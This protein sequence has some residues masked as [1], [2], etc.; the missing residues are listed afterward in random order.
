MKKTQKIFALL[1]AV[2]MIFSCFSMVVMAEEEKQN[3]TIVGAT[4]INE[5]EYV[6]EFSAPVRFNYLW[7]TFRR[8][9]GYG[10]GTNQNPSAPSASYL[11][12]ITTVDGKEY[13][14]TVKLTFKN[15]DVN[16]ENAFDPDT[17]HW[18]KFGISIAEYGMNT[19]EKGDA[20]GIISPAVISG[21][22]GEYVASN[23]VGAN[24]FLWIPTGAADPNGTYSVHLRNEDDIKIIGAEVSADKTT[25][26]LRFSDPVNV[27]AR[28]SVWFRANSPETGTGQVFPDSV[29]YL[30]KTYTYGGRVYSDTVKLVI[31]PDGGKDEA[32]GNKTFR[33]ATNDLTSYGI[34]FTEYTNN[35]ATHAG[36]VL[37]SVVT[38]AY[39]K[40]VKGNYTSGGRDFLWVPTYAVDTD[41]AY[42]VHLN[43]DGLPYVVSA[44]RLAGTST[45]RVEFSEPVAYTGG[46]WDIIMRDSP[47]SG[48][49]QAK[50]ASA[51]PAVSGTT[52]TVD[53]VTY[54]TI[55][56]FKSNDISAISADGA[57]GMAICEYNDTDHKYDGVVTA[58]HI[59][60]VDG[61]GLMPTYTGKPVPERNDPGMDLCWI[62]TDAADTANV[63]PIHLEEEKL[64]EKIEVATYEALVEAVAKYSKQTIY[65]TEDLV[66][67][68]GITYEYDEETGKVLILDTEGSVVAAY[69]TGNKGTVGGE[70]IEGSIEDLA[71]WTPFNVKNNVIDFQDHKVSGWVLGASGNRYGIF[72]AIDATGTVKNLNIENVFTCVNGV[73]SARIGA[74]AAQNW[75]TVE[76]VHIKDAVIIAANSKNNYVG[77]AVGYMSSSKAAQNETF[78]STLYNVTTDGYLFVYSNEDSTSPCIGGILGKTNGGKI[79]NC[80]NYADIYQNSIKSYGTGGIVGL[81]ETAAG[82]PFS[83]TTDFTTK[84]LE[85]M[86]VVNNANYGKIE[87]SAGLYAGGL[88]GYADAI[89]SAGSS[90][91]I[92]NNF[93]GAKVIGGKSGIVARSQ[94]VSSLGSITAVYE[95][96]FDDI[97]NGNP[98]AKLGATFAAN[99]VRLTTQ[100]DALENL[101]RN[102]GKYQAVNGEE[103]AKAWAWEK[104]GEI[105]LPVAT[106]EVG[107]V[108][109]ATPVTIP[110]YTF[111]PETEIGILSVKLAKPGWLEVTFSEPVKASGCYA[112]I[113]YV[114][115][116]YGIP[117]LIYADLAGDGSANDPVQFDRG[118]TI[119]TDY[120]KVYFAI[121]D[122]TNAVSNDILDKLSGAAFGDKVSGH[123]VAFCIEG[124]PV[125][126]GEALVEGMNEVGYIDTIT[127]LDGTKKL[128][129]SVGKSNAS[130]TYDGVY[131]AIENPYE[132]GDFV[133]PEASDDYVVLESAELAGPH[134]LK[135][136][137]SE[138]VKLLEGT[139]AWLSIRYCKYAADGYTPNYMSEGGK[140]CQVGVTITDSFV[141]EEDGTYVVNFGDTVD[142]RAV[143]NG[144]AW[145][146]ADAILISIEQLPAQ[147][148]DYNGTI[149]F[150][151]NIVSLDG[152]R[153]LAASP[154]KMD[155]SKNEAGEYGP[156][157]GAYAYIAEH[158]CAYTEVGGDEEYHWNECLCGIVDE[159]SIAAHDFVIE[160]Y[161][162]ENHWLECECGAKYE[163]TPHDFTEAASDDEYHWLECECG[164]EGEKT[165]HDYVNLV[166][167]DAEHWLECECG[168]IDPESV[169]DHVFNIPDHD[170]EYHWNACVCGAIDEEIPHEYGDGDT[171]ECG[172]KKYIVGDLDGDESKEASDAIYLLYNT[173]FGD[174]DYPVNQPV[175]FNNDG[176]TNAEDAIYLLYNVFFGDEDYPLFPVAE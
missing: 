173:F 4:M 144:E 172:N 23:V 109:E 126:E 8:Q 39:G 28:S 55:L 136:K 1:L 27:G 41:F 155:T 35:S 54:G 156:Y 48:T 30:G 72:D 65:V 43:T 31:N 167:G 97:A 18:D 20:Q 66:A 150:L 70:L 46:V 151:D 60:D 26:T 102:V 135:L 86:Y 116:S 78:N 36:Y 68:E 140:P 92:A 175:D 2:M 124:V 146:G 104:V 81:I 37:P 85:N 168:A 29:E 105:I 145:E 14:A 143:V 32:T 110:E 141:C 152:E 93:N 106:A 53:G 24:D 163:V 118:G 162:E 94:N 123:E 120:D 69:G 84:T 57:Y 3:I 154:A 157:D 25:Y 42:K 34:S 22:N 171:C 95:F 119:W 15:P 83:E 91:I 75:G 160:N 47:E 134:S 76:N 45:I 165:A 71:V 88:V 58:K 128:K 138:P 137:F 63:Y 40:M 17:F 149:G 11:G 101:N 111:D 108:K 12:E 59:K 74:L 33:E 153:M 5:Y 56:D 98:F 73:A 80:V 170:S 169:E 7:S 117:D 100:A 107:E 125:K 127:S 132:D 142:M 77:V 38:G 52:V 51:T 133:N 99:A 89:W 10:D 148:A 82:G 164:A 122:N 9:G 121:S 87:T 147:I 161:D 174:E 61:N 67:N 139:R 13:S 44:T 49:N 79:V 158:V 6:L 90:V 21:A 16:G 62:P 103:F 131:F 64:P 176:E 112:G 130:G 96:N 19:P 166:D 113:R 159:N 114:D 50:L 115:V 129:A